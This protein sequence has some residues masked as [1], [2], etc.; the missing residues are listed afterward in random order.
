MSKL[1]KAAAR[2]EPETCDFLKALDFYKY[3]PHGLA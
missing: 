1:K 2:E 3:L